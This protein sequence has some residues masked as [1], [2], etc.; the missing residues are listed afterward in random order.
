MNSIIRCALSNALRRSKGIDDRSTCAPTAKELLE[1]FDLRS[2]SYIILHYEIM[3]EMNE[4]VLEQ[5]LREISIN[6]K[7][8]K[9]IESNSYEQIDVLI[10]EIGYRNLVLEIEENGEE[11]CEGIALD[12]LELRDKEIEQEVISLANERRARIKREIKEL[13]SYL[14]DLCEK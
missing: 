4:E 13:N 3:K 10:D 11:A 2:Y 8:R 7:I 14:Y 5:W 9:A 1:Y 12:A 6:E